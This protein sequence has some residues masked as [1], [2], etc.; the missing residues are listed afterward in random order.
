MKA[1]VHFHCIPESYI[2]AI[3]EDSHQYPDAVRTDASGQEEILL[4]GAWW[5]PLTGTF[6]KE[7]SRMIQDMDQTSRDVAVLSV[8]PRLLHYELD[9]DTG[10]RIAEENGE[11][12]EV[13]EFEIPPNLTYAEID[14]KTGLLATPICQWAMR[15][16]FLPGT[17]PNRFCTYEDHMM[18][19]DYYESLRE[20]EQDQ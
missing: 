16:I 10:E 2:S 1:D 12:L 7:M 9:A 3:R 17:E 6:H 8:A 20:R 14:R 18:V 13:E 11:E 15:E 4:A 5:R 19:L